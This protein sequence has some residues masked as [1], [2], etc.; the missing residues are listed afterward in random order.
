MSSSPKKQ[1]KT[2]ERKVR[3]RFAP[4][5]TG[6]LH[7]GGVRTCLYN[8]LF[9]KQHGGD[10]IFRIE[11][12][13]SNRFVP[14]AEEY[15]IEALE[16]LGI[17]FDEG[18]SYGG[19][20]GPYRQSERRDIYRK[21]VDQ[22]LESGH[23]YIAFDTPEEL[24]AKRN[25]I[26]NFQ[27]DASTR[28]QM[29]NSLSLSK[30][31]VDARIARGDQY[32]VRAKIEPNEEI[33]V[34]D[35]IRGDVHVNSSILDDKVLYKSADNL[36]TYHLANIVDDHLMEVSHVIRGEEWLPSAPLH[37]LLYRF[38]GWEDTMPQFAHLALL[39]KPDGNG[40]LSKRDGDRLG[41]PVFPLRWVDPKSGEVSSGYR[42]SGYYSEAFI[43]MLALLGWNPGTEQEIFSMEELI[44][45]FSFEHCTKSG[46]RFN[47]DKT[48][49]FNH[50]YLL[51]KDKE[52]VGEEYLQWLET[53]KGIKAD[54]D[55]VVKVA[56]LVKDRVN[57]VKELWDQS[58]FFFEAPTSYDEVTVKKRWKENSPELMR[59]AKELI[60]GIEDF[61]AENIEKV[62]NEWITSNE[63]GMGPVM[64]GLRLMLVGAGKGP[65][66]HEILELIGKEEAVKR[67]DKGVEVLG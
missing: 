10:M 40:K 23:A 57:F 1:Y 22:L 17:K 49:W 4:S 34:H 48:K 51:K 35:I 41:F 46:A 31:E 42:E 16:W 8:Y 60:N 38:F 65:H 9:A 24:E 26:A 44:E 58:F 33:V 61:S 25:E 5:P 28:M 56:G 29:S 67:I 14:G 55:Y 54:R 36:P 64:N 45:A 63:L 7:I 15:I 43:N 39:L 13:D 21:Y 30:E 18:V 12:T 32:V 6:A 11:D 2:M 53:E 3:V 37:V 66:I 62:L 27:Y 47:V 50:E 59:M 19:N 20:Y 52:E